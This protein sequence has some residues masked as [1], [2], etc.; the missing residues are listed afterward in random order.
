M[1]RPQRTLPRGSIAHVTNRGV[2][3]QVI[4][5]TD[6]DRR[7]FLWLVQRQV[8]KRGWDCHGYCLMDNHYHLLIQAPRGDVSR[9]MQAIGGAY[10]NMFNR[11]NTRTGHVFE[12][13]FGAA[14]VEQQQHALELARYI[15]LNPVRAGLVDRPERWPWSSYACLHSVRWLFPGLRSDWF[16][17]QFGGRGGLVR[18]VESGLAVSGT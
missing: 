13:R 15:A 12:G 6:A 7:V 9:G 4:F 3:G 5:R 1:G 17:E 8:E 10:S 2:A 16:I 18:F 14:L 11:A